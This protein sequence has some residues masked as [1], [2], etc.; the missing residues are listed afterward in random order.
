MTPWISAGNDP[1]VKNLIIRMEQTAPGNHFILQ[2][3]N[4]QQLATSIKLTNDQG[5]T[6]HRKQIKN[7]N[8]RHLKYIMKGFKDGIYHLIIEWNNETI[9][10]S[11]SKKGKQIEFNSTSDIRR[12]QS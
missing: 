12:S 3:A 11:L 1:S 7:A 6:L 9:V 2:V 5:E 10:Y 4:L 8:G